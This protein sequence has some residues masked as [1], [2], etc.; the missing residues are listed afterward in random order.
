MKLL[1][2]L[3]NPGRQY[4]ATRHNVGWM[5][6]QLLGKRLAGRW[7]ERFHAKVLAKP[8]QALVLLLPQTMMN[9]SGEAVRLAVKQWR[10]A[11]ADLLI[12]C[13]DVNLPLGMLRLRPKG[14]DGGH[15]GLAS[16]LEALQTEEVPRLRVGVAAEPLPRDLT[17]FVL[18]A[19]RP[20]QQRALDQVLERAVE[21]CEVWVREGIHAAMN[22][23][24]PKPGRR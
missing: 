21:A 23:A 9:V 16:C 6:V 5:V 13:D 22:R 3:G 8:A 18:S 1:V 4:A 7:D 11:P 19:F 20:A 10:V 2:G 12:V 15:H 17:D 14:S 24:N